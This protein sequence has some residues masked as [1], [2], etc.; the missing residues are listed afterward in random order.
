MFAIVTVMLI[1]ENCETRRKRWIK[2]E[3]RSRRR[4]S[5]GTRQQPGFRYMEQLHLEAG[6]RE[7]HH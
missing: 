5:P 6:R 3:Y 7:E 1:K 4:L 2:D